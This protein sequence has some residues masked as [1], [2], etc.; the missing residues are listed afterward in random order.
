MLRDWNT[1]ASIART[2]GNQGLPTWR[3]VLYIA[4]AFLRPAAML[5]LT[6]S[7]TSCVYVP[8]LNCDID[9]NFILLMNGWL[10]DRSN[11]QT[12]FHMYCFVCAMQLC[13]DCIYS[14]TADEALLHKDEF[15]HFVKGLSW[16]SE[17]RLI[18]DMERM[19]TLLLRHSAN[20]LTAQGER[21]ATSP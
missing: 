7:Y 9:G 20:G 4:G 16:V 11:A 6:P 15:L 1:F 3:Q 8:N 21:R 17:V 19:L 2:V 12:Q 13:V 5:Q 18:W 14:Y 10:Q